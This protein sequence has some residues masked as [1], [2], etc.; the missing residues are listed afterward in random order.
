MHDKNFIIGFFIITINLIFHPSTS[1]GEDD[2]LSLSDLTQLKNS[3]FKDLSRQTLGPRLTIVREAGLFIG[4]RG[5]FA[6][7]VA[8]LNSKLEEKDRL[9][10]QIYD[11]SRL[12]AVTSSGHLMLPPI[13]TEQKSSL[14]I[15]QTGEMLVERD[16]VF[17]IIEPARLTSVVP[18][19]SSYITLSPD[20]VQIEDSR[21]LPRNKE[22]EKIWSSAVKEGWQIGEAQGLAVFEEGL[23]VLERDFLGM[24]LY[25]ELLKKGLVNEWIIA[26]SRQGVIKD[27]DTM[28]V[29]GILVRITL[30][31]GFNTDTKNWKPIIIR[32]EWKK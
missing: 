3:V 6:D 29:G 4:T 8:K 9:L 31:V 23:R 30:P 14:E 21:V 11:F 19:Y 12:I 2:P 32:G 28:L 25:R 16:L 15:N 13:V 10:R 18:D 17:E 22:E 1:F 26:T 27:G 20:P 24:A 7:Y 5:G